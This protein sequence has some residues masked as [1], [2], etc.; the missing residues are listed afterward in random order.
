MEKFLIVLFKNKK[1]KKIIKKFITYQKAKEGYKKI[2]EKSNGVIFEVKV[3][4]GHNVDYEVGLVD[5]TSQTKFPTYKRDDLG[6]N[7][8]IQMEDIGFSVLQIE[9]YK[10]EERIFD[11]QKNKKITIP[12]LI[13]TYLFSKDLKIISLLNNKL[14]VQKDE[15]INLF[16]LKNESEVSR[17]I[18]VLQ[19]KFLNENRNDCMFITD[20]STPQRKFLLN[21]L[22]E[23]GY[24]K[25]I[26]YR[27]YTTHPR[28]KA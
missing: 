27:N 28:T 11:L 10:K 21:L 16:S 24:N 22:S 7:L 13:K 2:I 20:D 26:L 1:K 14:I 18:I 5:T 12:Y 23:K 25:K 6:R 4:N 8:K 19:T 15:E 3:E 9:N 17:L